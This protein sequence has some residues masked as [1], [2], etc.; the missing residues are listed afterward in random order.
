WD[1]SGGLTPPDSVAT[2]VTEAGR[3]PIWDTPG[4]ERWPTGSAFSGAVADAAALPV[5]ETGAAVL[6][7]PFAPWFDGDR[8]CADVELPG[9]AAS[10]YAPFVRLAVA[11]YQPES[12]ADHHLSPIVRTE[13]I[14]L[15]PDRTLTV[16]QV[17]EAVRVQLAGIGPAGPRANRVDVVLEQCDAPGVDA[18]TVELSAL[19]AVGEVPVWT[20]V[21]GSTA[22]TELGAAPVELPLPAGL[23]AL[24]LRLREVEQIGGESV[25]PPQVTTPGELSERVV[26]ADT[27]DLPLG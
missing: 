25:P 9:I 21:P 17:G 26:F 12:I 4:P 20:P 1:R 16:S 3:D 11:R 15:L 5:V 23:G 18:T 22:Q 13:M 14:Q 2:L 10:S 6:A 24:R 19:G 27:V 8:W 7:V